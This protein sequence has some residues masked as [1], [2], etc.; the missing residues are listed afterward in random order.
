MRRAVAKW[1]EAASYRN[2]LR[3][4]E[5]HLQSAARKWLL[6]RMLAKWR[7]TARAVRFLRSCY[8]RRGL[9]AWRKH[10]AYNQV[11][12]AD[13]ASAGS[14]RNWSDL[15]GLCAQQVD[16]YPKGMLI[17]Y[18]VRIGPAAPCACLQAKRRQ[19]HGI[20]QLLLHGCV[21]RCFVAWREVTQVSCSLV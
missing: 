3:G 19:L 20:A 15:S 8:L 5:T 16:Q 13:G 17:V 18:F 2:A 12:W 1:Q 4:A 14:A 11:G 10:A 7:R 6:A 21:A 9:L